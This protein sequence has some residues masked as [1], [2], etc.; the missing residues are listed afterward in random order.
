MVTA[1]IR[2]RILY[3]E[4]PG[5]RKWLALTGS[6]DIPLSCIVSAARGEPGLPKFRSGDL[7]LGGT[8]LPGLLA[9][10]RYRMGSPPRRTFLALRRSSR[11]VLVL[12]LRDY[13]YDIVR[14][15]VDDV[16]GVLAMI[17]N[18]GG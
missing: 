10:G 18:A 8:G 17:R 15:E 4:I 9:M 2:D 16:A 5:W 11:E 6:L 13:R 3:L 1:S 14:V 7:R 12:E